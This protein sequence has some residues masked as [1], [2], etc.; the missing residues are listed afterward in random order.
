M[1]MRAPPIHPLAAPLLLAATALL[2]LGAVLRQAPPAVSVPA[3]PAALPVA[4][5][6]TERP[7]ARAAADAIAILARPL[8]TPDRSPAPDLAAAR[9]A[10]RI[11]RLAGTIVVDDGTRRA[12]LSGP[13]GGA[14]VLREGERSGALTVRRIDPG[15][16][17]A[18]TPAGPVTLTLAAG[19]ADVVR[20]VAATIADAPMTKDP[21]SRN[22]NNQDE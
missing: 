3:P 19:G 20:T 2:A 12:V 18:D 6:A 8:F 15:R 9:P 17:Q 11:P 22:A 1:T 10:P 13:D 4:A 21:R 7:S 16:V 14:V 5:P